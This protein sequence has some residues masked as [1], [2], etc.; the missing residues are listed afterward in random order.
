VTD[1]DAAR[2]VLPRGLVPPAGRAVILIDGGSGAGKSSLAQ[3]LALAWPG[4]LRVVSLDDVFPGWDGLAEASDRVVSDLLRRDSPGYRRWDWHAGAPAEW[5]PLDPAESLVVEGCGALTPASRALATAGI[6]VVGDPATRRA[7][8]IA[9][10]G[11]ELAAHWAQW[12]AQERAHWRR[13]HPRAL[14][15]WWFVDGRFVRRTPA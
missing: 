10:D 4:P 8:A 5:V 15:D 2:L 7:R 11:E 1:A 14:A 13:H 3:A 6:W 12:A 9:R